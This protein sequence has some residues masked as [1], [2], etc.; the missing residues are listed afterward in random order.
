MQVDSSYI[1]QT[2]KFLICQTETSLTVRYKHLRDLLEQFC[3]SL[4]ET[5][6]LNITDLSA[7]ISLFASKYKLTTAEQNRLHTLRITANTLLNEKEQSVNEA[8]FLRDV[9]T[10]AF[11]VRKV[12]KIDIPS[13]LYALLPEAD[14]TYHIMPLGKKSYDEL[15]VVFVCA[16][17]DFLYVRPTD[18]VSDNLLKV[19]CNVEQVNDVFNDTLDKLWPYCRLNLLDISVD[20]DGVLIP[21]MIVLE[22]AYL[23]DISSLAECFKDYGHDSANYLLGRLKSTEN[24]RPLLLGNIVN[25]FLDEWIHAENEPEYIECMQKA[26]RQYP[27][28]IATCTDLMDSE[29]ERAFFTDCKKHFDNLRQIV[30]KTFLE[31]GYELDKNDAVLEPSYICEALGLQGRLD[32]MQRDMQAFIEMKSGKAEEYKFKGKIEPREN[33]WTQMLLYQAVLQ[34][35]MHKEHHSVKSYLLYTRYPLL[36][37]SRPSWAQVKRAINLRNLIVAGDYNVQFHNATDYTASYLQQINAEEMNKKALSGKLWEQYL[38]PAIENYASSLS[39][40]SSLERSYYYALYNFIVKELYTAKMQITWFSTFDEKLDAGEI[41]ANMKLVENRASDAHK[42]YVVFAPE[43]NDSD[44]SVMSNFREGD[45]VLFYE[46][47]SKDDNVTNKLVFKGNIESITSTFLKV[48]L[49]AS[50]RNT[51]V[52]PSD[53]FY[54]MEHDYMDSSFRLMFQSLDAYTK[55]SQSRRD[56]LLAQREPCF[57]K[58]YDEQIA[59]AANNFDRIALKAMAAK[60]YFLLVGPPGSGKTSCALKSMVEHFYRSKEPNQILLM[61]YTNRAVDEI[62]KSLLRISPQIDFIRIGS[63]LSCEES[64][65]PYLLENRISES[66]RR[67]EVQHIITSCSVFVGTVASI[68]A[69]PEL[70]RLKTFNVA[71]IDEATQILEP[72]LLGLL[73]LKDKDGHDAIS[74]FVMIG[75]YKQLP[76]VVMQDDT[77]SAV[78]S[79]DLRSIGITNLKDSLF[80]RLHR[81]NKNERA[82]DILR[83]QGRMHPDI[84]AFSNNAFYGGELEIVGLPHQKEIVPYKRMV[85]ISSNPERN[86]LSGK[87]NCSEAEIVAQKAVEIYKREAEQFDVSHTLGIIAPYRS[88]IALIRKELAS[89]DIPALN[90]IMVD[91]VERY[92]GSEKDII[93]YSCCINFREQFD[94]L[95][96]K[97]D[98][99]GQQIDRKLNVALTRARKQMIVIGASNILKENDIYRKLI[100]TIG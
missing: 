23:I 36:Y 88:Q 43:Q 18:D 65:R 91:T 56:L 13:D 87:T 71:I 22:P 61:A 39:A 50:Q 25:L 52:L 32:Y 21:Q 90:E 33:H 47:N 73:C 97:I 24:T 46:R 74:R 78:M 76:A 55:A 95:V 29:K 49:R 99:D 7:R 5:E 19:H 30:K 16:E 26:F 9:K 100:E 66:K 6:A 48:R 63:E 45:I 42:A 86:T 10:M 12:L 69:K 89:Y 8:S 2:L 20:D 1:F 14:A 81:N 54:A 35:T 17:N 98:V 4:L 64:Y 92:Q 53:S 51:A 44:V 83:Y 15:H 60:D 93:I 3:L 85:F 62:C 68:S 82:C 70:F 67:S 58:S 84:A 75:D 94:F 72:Q 37:P 40:M 27:I 59:S 34:Y 28:E 41:M 79:E 57:D 31:S 96:N 77:Q 80:E 38:K 11:V